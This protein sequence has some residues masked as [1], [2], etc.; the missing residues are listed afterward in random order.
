VITFLTGFPTLLATI[1]SMHAILQ[2]L[3]AEFHGNTG[4]A[5]GPGI[6]LAYGAGLMAAAGGSLA[7]WASRHETVGRA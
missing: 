7:L 5:I 4:V 6:W 3:P 1:A 2:F